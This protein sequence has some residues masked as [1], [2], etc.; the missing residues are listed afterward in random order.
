V[1]G[2]FSLLRIRRAPSACTDCSLC[3]KPCPVGI[4]PSKAQPFV[5]TDCIGCMDCV[6]TCPVRGA[7]SVGTRVSLGM[8]NRIRKAD[9]R[10]PVRREPASA[11][12]EK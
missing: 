3:D 4:E 9:L 11:G 10:E 6:A 1:V 5:S 2:R 7:L 12:K 8:P